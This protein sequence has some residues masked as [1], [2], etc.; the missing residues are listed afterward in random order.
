MDINRKMSDFR[1]NL[2]LALATKFHYLIILGVIAG[3]ALTLVIGRSDYAVR[4]LI[5]IVPG[6]LAAILLLVIYR[7]GMKYPDSLILL[8]AN[9]KVF[10]LTFV[11]LFTLSILALY[12]SPYRPWYYFLLITALFCVVFLQIFTDD[13]K[14]TILLFEMSCV[15]GNIIFGLQLKYPFYFGYTDIIPHLFLSKIIVLSGHI[16]PI[17]LD[18]GYAWFPLYHIFIAEGTNLFGTDEK[19]SFIILTSLCYLVLLWVD[20]LLFNQVTKNTQMSLLT[21]LIFSTTPVVITYST[22]VVTRTMA[23]IGFIF[24]IFLA[25]KQIQTSKW[26]SFSALTLLFSLY[27]ILV[28]QVSILQILVLLVLFIILELLVND[29]FVIKTKTLAFIIVTF[30]AYWIYTSIQLTDTILKSATFASNTPEL[31]QLKPQVMGYEYI[32]LEKNIT[33]AIFIFFVILGIGYL[34][35]AYKAKY[36]SVIGLFVLCMSLLYF[37]SPIAASK[38]AMVM[39]RT[40][41]FSLLLSPF[42]AFVIAI[43]FLLVLFIFYENKYTRKIALLFGVL[44]FSYLCFSAITGDNAT[45]SLD[46]PSDE[47]RVYFTEPEMNAFN[48][49]PAFIKYNSTISTDRFSSRMFDQKFFSETEALNLPSFISTFSLEPADTYKFNGFFVLRNQE[50]EKNGLQFQSRHANATDS[51][52]GVMFEPTQDTLFKFSNMTFSSQKIYDNHMVSILAN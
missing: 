29:Y 41:R 2:I 51:W 39:L 4:G 30:S 31:S 3:I 7:R 11:V 26:L 33:T 37:P 47:M 44:I 19:F 1:S 16:I 9:R 40:D 14:P 52:Y 24:F 46:L 18:Y 36:L 23:F 48:F 6:I 5:Y 43:G 10:Y 21:C 22:Y 8:Q 35:W 38:I 20:Y 32:F 49:I 17:D 34:C 27:L 25:H 50:L 15:M 42:F 13:L 12:Y 28:H 45:D